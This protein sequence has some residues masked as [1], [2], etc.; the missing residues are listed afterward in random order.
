MIVATLDE[1]RG[2]I[3][4]WIEEGKQLL[5]YGHTL[6]GTINSRYSALP[7]ISKHDMSF[8]QNN[9]ARNWSNRAKHRIGALLLTPYPLNHISATDDVEENGQNIK[10]NLKKASIA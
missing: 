2:E 8:E 10:T 5:L 1:V 7:P 3:Q 6:V 4:E 9:A